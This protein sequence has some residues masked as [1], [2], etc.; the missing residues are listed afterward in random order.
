MHV[1][2]THGRVVPEVRA[3]KR[4]HAGHAGHTQSRISGQRYV[5]HAYTNTHSQSIYFYVHVRKG[6][7]TSKGFWPLYLIM[8][9][10]VTANRR[11][12]LTLT[13]AGFNATRP[14]IRP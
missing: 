4:A 12:T 7:D 8:F 13:P 5:L 10:V 3:Q 6:S 11:L 1:G 14:N 9:T 2:A